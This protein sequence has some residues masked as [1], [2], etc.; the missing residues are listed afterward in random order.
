[1]TAQ[2]TGGADWMRRAGLQ[3]LPRRQFVRDDA[4]RRRVAGLARESCNAISAGAG[5]RG[6]G[7]LSGENFES[8]CAARPI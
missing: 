7:M 4:A 6:A 2:T 8:A 5:D 1:M 3:R